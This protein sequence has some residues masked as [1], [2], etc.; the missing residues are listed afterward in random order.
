MGPEEQKQF[1]ARMKDR[2]VDTSEF[3]AML[4]G[5][6][7]AKSGAGSAGAGFVFTPRYGPPQSDEEIEKLFRPLPA[8]QTQGR[9]W[10]FVDR[11]LKPIG[12]RLGI[13]DGTL[14]ELLSGDLQEG[15]EV[16]TGVTGATSARAPAAGAGN[17]VLGPQGG[18]GFGRG[19]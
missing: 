13:T 11:Q 8:V 15:T 17:P 7:G 18:R 2:G 16:V 14:T 10:L 6:G 3:E 12:L 5:T 19:F 9:V 1:L 4:G